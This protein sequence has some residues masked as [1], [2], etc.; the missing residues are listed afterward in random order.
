MLDAQKV[1][2]SW[3]VNCR[4]LLP[5]FPTLTHFLVDFRQASRVEL[6]RNS[7]RRR[8]QP[9]LHLCRKCGSAEPKSSVLK[10]HPLVNQLQ[11]KSQAFK[12]EP[13]NLGKFQPQQ[14][15]LGT[16]SSNITKN[17]TQN[18]SPSQN[19]SIFKPKAKQTNQTETNKNPNKTKKTQKQNQNQT[20]TKTKTRHTHLTHL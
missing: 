11:G 1:S 15:F 6:L 4:F 18:I 3:V 8:D 5:S 7:L 16:T 9:A 17:L 10:A 20:K 13:R 12:K 19:S 14:K 2:T